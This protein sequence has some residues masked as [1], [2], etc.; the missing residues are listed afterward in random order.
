MNNTFIGN[1]RHVQLTR[2][3]VSFQVDQQ[4]LE[5]TVTD[6]KYKHILTG[7]N[8]HTKHTLCIFYY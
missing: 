5:P 8:T 6:L 1:L 7:A 4:N 3:L 2:P